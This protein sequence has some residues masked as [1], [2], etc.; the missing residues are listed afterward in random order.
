MEKQI[1][2][3]PAFLH[4]EVRIILMKEPRDPKN[5]LSVLQP[6]TLGNARLND[7]VQGMEIERGPVCKCLSVFQGLKLVEREVP[8]IEK[9]PAKSRKGVYR[10]F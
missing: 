6:I 4:D 7:I 2:S 5:Y 8:V 1:L 3:P 9:H 10:L